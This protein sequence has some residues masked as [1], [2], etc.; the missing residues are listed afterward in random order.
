MRRCPE[1]GKSGRRAIMVREVLFGVLL[2]GSTM[3]QAAEPAKLVLACQGH[4][5]YLGDDSQLLPVSL[6]LTVNLADRTIQG[7]HYPED[8]PIKITDI[9]ETTIVFHGSSR[10]APGATYRQINGGIDRVTG[11]AEAT[12]DVTSWRESKASAIHSL[13]CRST[14]PMF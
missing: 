13:K 1:R 5:H 2:V 7:F 14:Q 9:N 12:S 11:D 3:S 6:G 8:F 10:H 4:T